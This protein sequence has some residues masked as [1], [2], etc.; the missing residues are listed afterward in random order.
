[1]STRTLI[2]AKMKGMVYTIYCHHDGYPEHIVPL[3]LNHYNT[4]EKVEALI[5]MGDTSAI[6]ETLEACEPYAKNGEPYKDNTP[7]ISTRWN[8]DSE[9]SYQY[10]WD[11]KKWLI[12]T[13]QSMSASL[14]K[15]EIS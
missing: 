4:Q 7:N 6:Y 11:G 9:Y 15:K 14:S 3:L 10:F 1:M 12:A 5:M 8:R 13:G 2:S